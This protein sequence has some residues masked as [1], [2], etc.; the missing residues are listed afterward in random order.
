MDELE[1]NLKYVPNYQVI[2]YICKQQKQITK[3]KLAVEKGGDTK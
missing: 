3:E 2:A 1:Q